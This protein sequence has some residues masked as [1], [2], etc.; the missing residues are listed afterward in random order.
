MTP[1]QLLG[2]LYLVFSAPFLWGTLDVE[3]S[4]GRPRLFNVRNGLTNVRFS[5]TSDGGT[6]AALTALGPVTN[7]SYFRFTAAREPRLNCKPSNV[8]AR[9]LSFDSERLRAMLSRPKS[10]EPN[11]LMLEKAY[12]SKRFLYA[13]RSSY[14]LGVRENSQ[15]NR[16]RGKDPAPVA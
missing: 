3:K 2:V 9:W 6:V 12:L 7:C 14:L 11:H 10:Y 13:A 5:R 16:R 15:G 1:G 4:F 8:T